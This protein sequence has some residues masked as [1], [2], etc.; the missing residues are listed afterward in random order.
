MWHL[1]EGGRES[2]KQTQSI[3]DKICKKK[4]FP[5]IEG[6]SSQV[7]NELSKRENEEVPRKRGCVGSPGSRAMSSFPE[8]PSCTTWQPSSRKWLGLSGTWCNEHACTGQ[9]S[10]KPVGQATHSWG[11]GIV[12]RSQN[13]GT[14]QKESGSMV[15]SNRNTCWLISAEKNVLKDSL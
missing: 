11:L 4:S 14:K 6:E 5:N 10:L 9:R 3:L 15:A 2:C 13:H 7:G 8:I 12:R 1:K